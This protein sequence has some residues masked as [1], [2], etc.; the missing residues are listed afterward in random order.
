[1]N[2]RS[3][4]TVDKSAWGDG[5]WQT[6]PDKTQW[7]DRATGLDCLIVRNPWGALCGYVGVPPEH[8]WH[9]RDYEAIPVECHGG[10][11][12]ADG[13]EKDI[14]RS[15]DND[16][17]IAWLTGRF[18]DGLIDT[19]PFEA[20]VAGVLS[21]EARGVCHVPAPGRPDDVWWFGFD[22]AHAFDLVP[23]LSVL[24]KPMADAFDWE[25]GQY[26]DIGYVM[27]ECADLA[28]QLAAAR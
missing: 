16:Q 25:H 23:G 8:P 15:A 27:S 2:E 22:C 1:M 18:T 6:E 4:F 14:D 13:C 7:I 12:F 9:G 24:G 17:I 20:S 11:T 3:Y 26:R 19:E 5:P 10:V 21:G 28:K